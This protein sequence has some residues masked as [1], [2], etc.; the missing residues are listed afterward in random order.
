MF[1][2]NDNKKDDRGQKKPPGGF[3]IPPFTWLAWIAII[4]SIVALMLVKNYH[5][6]Q[7]NNTLSQSEFL[8]KFESNQIAHATISYNPQSLP[9]R[10]NITGTYFQDG[11]RRECC[12]AT[13]WQAG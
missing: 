12:Q 13:Q 3:K 1:D 2:E 7:S 6:I 11:Q 9:T 8:Q 5:A 10:R 4:G